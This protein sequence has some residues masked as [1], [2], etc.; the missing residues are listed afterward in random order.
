MEWRLRLPPGFG[1]RLRSQD[2]VTDPWLGSLPAQVQDVCDRWWLTPD[3]LAHGG[4]TSLVIP[5]LT[6]EGKSAAL[7]LV[8]PLADPAEEKR[9]LGMLAGHGVV[10]CLRADADLRALL[11]ERLDG[12]SLAAVADPLEAARIAGELA[13]RIGSVPAPADAPRLSAR[14]ADWLRVLQEQHARAE[15]E[16]AALGMG[17]VRRAFDVVEELA[18]DATVTLTHG[19]LSSQN[20]LRRADGSWCAIDPDLLCGP[21]EYEAHTVLRGV[22]P[23]SADASDV[24]EVMASVTEQFCLAANADPVWV[25]A[26]SHARFVASYYWEAQHEGDPQNIA[27]LRA[28]AEVGV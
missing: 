6:S 24:G 23:S 21:R 5:V 16:G 22:L 19:D 14:S 13:R 9:A 3:G 20:V 2:G 15:H 27:L 28:A 4:G 1:Q 12:P 17:V 8:S 25:Q 11:L 7:K 26:L 18:A 10:E